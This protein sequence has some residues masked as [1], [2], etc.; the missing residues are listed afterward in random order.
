MRKILSSRDLLKLWKSESWQLT[1][2]LLRN[3]STRF[4]K[5]EL[6]DRSEKEHCCHMFQSILSYFE[7]LQFNYPW[8][9]LCIVNFSKKITYNPRPGS[10]GGASAIFKAGN[11]HTKI[12]VPRERALFRDSGCGVTS[13]Y[14][15][16]NPDKKKSLMVKTLVLSFKWKMNRG[17]VSFFPASHANSVSPELK[18]LAGDYGKNDTGFGGW[19]LGPTDP[20]GCLQVDLKTQAPLKSMFSLWFFF[21]SASIQ[22]AY[23]TV[24]ENS[25]YLK[26]N[27]RNQH[28]LYICT[29]IMLQKK[30]SMKTSSGAHKRRGY[31]CIFEACEMREFVFATKRKSRGKIRYVHFKIVAENM[32]KNTNWKVW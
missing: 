27:K 32:T 28:R 25:P 30:C 9:L 12:I 8:T 1:V 4:P 17:P 22:W 16:S 20:T 6:Y 13:T 26:V 2:S 3:G 24:A 19:G 7:I 14:G 15:D 18:E 10:F 11:L 23:A 29:F 5:Y 21:L 31:Y